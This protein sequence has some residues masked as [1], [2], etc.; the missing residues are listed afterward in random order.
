MN[1]R[2]AA[3]IPL[4][5]VAL[6]GRQ[7]GAEVPITSADG[8]NLSADGRLNTF[9]S[10]AH[11]DAQPTPIATWTGVE[12]RAAGGDTITSSRIRSGLVMN[13][14]GFNVV[15]ELSP[16]LKVTGRFATWV[17]VAQNRNKSDNPSL[18][19]REVYFKLEGRWGGILAG[20]N[21]SLFERG[22]IM[23]DY[24][25]EH[26]YGLGHPCAVRTSAGG[27]CGHAGHG[28]LY[29][30][31][32]AGF[33]YNTPELSGFQL[34]VGAYDPAAISERTYERTPFPRLEAELTWKVRNFSLFA[35][36]L[37]QR[38]GNNNP[39]TD[40]SGNVV[41]DD[42]GKPVQQDADATGL[43]AGA[44]VSLGPLTVGAAVYAGKGLGLYVPMENSPL[45]A[46]EKKVLRRSQ[47]AVG[48]ASIV[49]GR[50]KI[51]GGI[52]VSQLK[53]SN[54]VLPDGTPLE[55]EP[56]AKLTF[57]K[58]Q[59]GISAGYYRGFSKTIF[60]ALEYFRGEYQWYDSLD[61]MGV[62]Q[63]NRQNVN[64]FNTGM[65]LIW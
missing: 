39:I 29:P 44:S 46:D 36:A 28:L 17:V 1:R 51:A 27:A 61:A 55:A 42:Q 34:S 64:F 57:P 31:Y 40:E 60:F 10:F 19:A 11:G 21:L 65:T 18:D 53:M 22:A 41:N 2:I 14:L 13:V 47:G 16:D 24:D 5:T 7:A 48:L 56:F 59:L 9:M 23:M 20:R 30:G 52:G 37:W 50:N 49:F 32:N 12:D 43:A 8:W 3:I 33:V 6:V 25:I 62:V 45:F 58:Q 63:T 35:D 38:V 26:A 54:V 4:A 15:K